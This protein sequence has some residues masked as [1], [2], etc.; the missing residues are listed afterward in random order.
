MAVTLEAPVLEE[1]APT[2]S[3]QSRYPVTVAHVS[4]GSVP[5]L[6]SHP[7]IQGPFE[8]RLSK[9]PVSTPS[10]SHCPLLQKGAQE[11]T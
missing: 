9:A 10:P 5:F 8:G 2:D 1:R 3:F 11:L 7:Y 6:L 4:Q